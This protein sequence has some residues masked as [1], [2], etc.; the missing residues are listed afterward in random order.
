MYSIYLRI[1]AATSVEGLI[2]G[3]WRRRQ[4]WNLRAPRYAFPYFVSP[5]PSSVCPALSHTG[6]IRRSIRMSLG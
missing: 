4:W 2:I 1:S 6:H 3:A 5:S